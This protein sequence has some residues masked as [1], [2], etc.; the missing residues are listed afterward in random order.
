MVLIKEKNRITVAKAPFRATATAINATGFV[1]KSLG[2]GICKLGKLAKL[3]E[4]SEW[5]AE[6]DVDARGNKISYPYEAD[7]TFI[8]SIKKTQ[9]KVFNEKGEKMWSDNDS[10]AS[11]VSVSEENIGKE[12]Y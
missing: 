9:I 11:T 1:L 12:I 5:I 10:I 7:V 6:A 8:P 2:S 4:R 3:G